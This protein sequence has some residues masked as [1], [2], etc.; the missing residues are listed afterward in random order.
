MFN[1][2]FVLILLPQTI[3]DHMTFY[4]RIEFLPLSLLFLYPFIFLYSQIFMCCMVV[5]SFMKDIDDLWTVL[6]INMSVFSI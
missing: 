5:Q 3:K 4:S 1:V 2:I 6:F